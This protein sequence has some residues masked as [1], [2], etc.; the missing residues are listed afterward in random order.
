MKK[1]LLAMK[2]SSWGEISYLSVCGSW[3]FPACTT[4]T[5]WSPI[6][7]GHSQPHEW[8]E[9]LCASLSLGYTV[10]RGRLMDYFLV[11]VLVLIGLISWSLLCRKMW[12]RSHRSLQRWANENGYTLVS[13][14][15]SWTKIPFRKGPYRWA[16]DLQIVFRVVVIDEQKM[17]WPAPRKLIQVE[18]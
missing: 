2:S 7:K 14:K 17:E 18:C 8:H 15:V 6:K 11:S 12:I 9:S 16:S 1:E 13:K 3:R 5:D 10:L 4:C